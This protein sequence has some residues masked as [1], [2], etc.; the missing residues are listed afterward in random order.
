MDCCWCGWERGGGLEN[1]G[2]ARRK[3]IQSCAA[4]ATAAHNA[5]VYAW[6]YT[7]TRTKRNM[8]CFGRECP[9]AAAVLCVTLGALRHSAPAAVSCQHWGCM[10]P[11]LIGHQQGSSPAGVH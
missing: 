10:E 11:L 7:W 6:A 2:G 1:G 4:K 9:W 3:C 8:G 5:Y